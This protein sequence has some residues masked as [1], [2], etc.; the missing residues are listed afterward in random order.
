MSACIVI[1]NILNRPFYTSIS[2]IQ[3]LI[4]KICY[5]FNSILPK[6]M[7]NSMSP[8]PQKVNLFG[9]GSVQIE[10][11]R[12]LGWTLN[13]AWSVSLWEEE[14]HGPTRGKYHVTTEADWSAMTAGQGIPRISPENQDLWRGKGQS[15]LRGCSGTRWYQTWSLRNCERIH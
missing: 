15:S 13:L 3:L 4:I 5:A 14:R 6:A 2:F 7:L 8:K 11:M 12:R 1:V 9:T 10:K